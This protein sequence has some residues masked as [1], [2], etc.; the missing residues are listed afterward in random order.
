MA[1]ISNYYCSLLKHCCEAGKHSQAKILHCNII[2]T[3]TDPETFLWN[4]VISTYAKLGLLTYARRVFDQI[5]YPNLFS[6]NTI[7]SVY[8]KSGKLREMHDI[9]T[10][11]PRRD[12]VSWNAIISGY[13]SSGLTSK[14]VEVYKLMLKDGPAYLN[15]ITFSTMI[16]LSSSEGSVDLGRQIHGQIVRCGFESYVFVGSPMVDMYAKFGLINDAQKVFDELP[17]RNLVTHNTMIMGLLRCGL[18]DDSKRLFL[19][20]SEKDSISWTTMIT[21]LTQNGLD[22]EAMDM[23]RLMRLEDLPIDQFT[24]G[25]ILTA[26]GSLASIKQGKQIH[27]Y[28][29]R[30]NYANNL[31]VASALIDMYSKCKRMNYAES[32]LNRMTTKNVVSWTAII[33]G[34]GQ[35][36]LSEKA[37]NALREM[38]RNGIQPDEF[39]FGSVISSCA[40]LASLEEGA[41]FHCRALVSSSISYVTVSNA[42]VTLYGK[43]GSL[44]NA[45]QLFDEMKFRD[46]VSWTAIVMGYAQFGKANETIEMFEKMLAVG[47]RP[48]EVTFIGVL[49]ACGRAGLVEKGRYYFESMAKEH[50]ILPI[51]EHYTCMIDVFSRAGKL[52]EARD[53]ILSMPY[54]PDTIG[55]VTLLS[56]CRIRREMVIGK[57]AAECLIE[58]EP[59]NPASYVLLSSMYAAKGEWEEVSKLRRVMRDK[60]VRKDRGCSWIKFR[61][62]VHVFSADDES[63]P[64]K[65]RIFEELGNLNRRMIEEGYEPD[66]SSILHDVGESEKI[67]MLNHHSEKLAIA[68][69]LIF[70]PNGLPIRVVKN[71]RVCADCHNATK[72]ISRITGR[73]ILV[74]DA[75]RYHLFKD[76]IC[77]CGDFW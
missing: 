46:E 60:G 70:I 53:F 20:M 40:N 73:E 8:S 55:W 66:T 64:Y 26:C 65:D 41:Q 48:D 27:A 69:G 14:S 13:A 62:R 58:V 17:E 29:I 63:N 50:G 12:G 10:R 33:V 4:N 11:I 7:L 68:F 56:S 3:I 30:T 31:F 67:S 21:G 28:V 32:V 39:T 36:G 75:V 51:Q 45:H 61:N 76:G 71:L 34:Y 6:W 1:Y 47:L 52:E 35:N 54:R 2:K 38:Q 16:L 24:F 37:V 43:C 23:L 15:R 19:Q 49:S 9:F 74:R 25:S 5:P 22:R 18:V 42:L 59:N 72:F 77:S 57:W 44:Q